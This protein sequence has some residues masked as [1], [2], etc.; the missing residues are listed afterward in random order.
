MNIIIR[1]IRHP[2]QGVGNVAWQITRKKSNSGHVFVFGAP[3]SGTTLIQSIIGSHPDFFSIKNETAVFT[4]QNIFNANRHFHGL[5]SN[6]I[7][8]VINSSNNSVE[9]LDNIVCKL[10]CKYDLK[11]VIFVEKTPQHVL[12]IKFILSRFCNSKA[13]NMVRDGRDGYRSSRTNKGVIQGSDARSFAKYWVRCIQAREAVGVHPRVLDVKYEDLV[14]YPEPVVRR[15]MKFLGSTFVP[16]QLDPAM[17]GD[18]PRANRTAFAKMGGPITAASIGAWREELTSEE[19][20][21]FESVA[22]PTLLRW[23]YSVG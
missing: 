20:E 1:L 17:F 12:R 16:P 6:D 2:V 21:T 22:G 9:Y 10:R 13:I 3:R 7:V 15:V 23:G 11:D 19:V 5:N 14:M 4:S 8:D 18:D